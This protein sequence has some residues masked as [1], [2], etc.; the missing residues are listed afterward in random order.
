MMV[1]EVTAGLEGVVCHMDNLLIWGITKEQHDERVHVVLQR[2]EKAGPTLN[3]KKCEF[4]KK[5]VFLGYIVSADGL[6]HDPD[7]TRAVQKLK[8]P[9]NTTEVRRFLGMV[10]RL[11]KFIPNL[12]E[13][14]KPL[15]D[16]LSKENQWYWGPEHQKTLN[17]L[18]QELSTS[19]VL[20]LYDPNIPLR[21]S[22]DVS[23]Y[24][25]RAVMLQKTGE[26]WA[27]VAYAS[28]SLR[29]TEQRYTQLEKEVLALTWACERFND[30][31]LGLH[32][33]LETDHKPLV[34][35]LGGR[36]LDSLPPQIQR[37]RMGLLRYS[38]T[39]SHT[40]GKSLMTADTL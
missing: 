25:L 34:C 14:D 16:L 22:T 23:S 3:L 21:I 38:Y 7:K 24:R 20:Q 29:V 28:Q 15:R 39:I 18:K 12:T 6:K 40:P 33:E 8:E 30:F 17:R 32:F 31:I 37:F 11:G 36:A 9:T 2:A 27:P 26:T 5:E 10:N 1:T 13:K 19:P 4:G 35:L